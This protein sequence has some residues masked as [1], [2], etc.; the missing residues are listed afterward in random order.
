MIRYTAGP[1]IAS[2]HPDDIYTQA[3]HTANSRAVDGILTD[4]GGMESEA[5][6][7]PW[8]KAGGPHGET[9]V[10]VE[11]EGEKSTITMVSTRTEEHQDTIYWRLK[12]HFVKDIIQLDKESIGIKSKIYL[13]VHQMIGI[14]LLNQPVSAGLM[15]GY[16]SL[17][18]QPPVQASSEIQETRP[19]ALATRDTMSGLFAERQFALK[20]WLR[21][22]LP[23]DYL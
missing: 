10:K 9:L 21:I 3:M 19:E 18:M 16:P 2:K 12:P 22:D 13:P 5:E 8:L 11:A 23:D 14:V 7:T 20:H 1:E 17:R 15:M 4:F 6:I